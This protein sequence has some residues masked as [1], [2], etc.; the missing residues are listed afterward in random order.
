[1]NPVV[2]IPAR[3]ASTRLPGKPLLSETGKYLIQHVYEQAR[4]SEK[5][6]EVIVATDDDRIVKAVKSFGG[7][8]ELTSTNHHTGTDRI[9]EVSAKIDSQIIINIQGDEPEI[10]PASIDL[11]IDALS[12]SPAEIPVATL[13]ARISDYSMLE[14]PNIVKVVT[15]LQNNALYFSRS[16][17]PY[18]RTYIE[19]ENYFLVHIGI[20]AYKRDFLMKFVKWAETPLEK[21]E[22]LEQLRILEHSCKIKVVPVE[23]FHKGIDTLEDY[24]L[25]VERYK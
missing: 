11:L 6:S 5:V 15:D 18:E 14:N 4:K 10:E 1:M 16:E 7:R 9:A 17:I 13:A 8:V 25:F 12:A 2:I 23:Q 24:K 22:K 20:Y 3:Y 19:N 21:I